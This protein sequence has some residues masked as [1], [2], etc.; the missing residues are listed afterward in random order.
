MADQFPRYSFT[1]EEGFKPVN[2]LARM[3]VQEKEAD[4]KRDSFAETYSP[5][6][7]ILDNDNALEYFENRK[8][9]AVS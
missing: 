6:V 5:S 8:L 1:Y 7:E 2:E 4:S 3:E 9:K